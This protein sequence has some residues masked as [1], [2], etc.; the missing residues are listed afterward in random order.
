MRTVVEQLEQGALV[1]VEGGSE[2]DEFDLADEDAD[3][4]A[5]DREEDSGE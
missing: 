3:E 5:E 2:A 4:E 1:A